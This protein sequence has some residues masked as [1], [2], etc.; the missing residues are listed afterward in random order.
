MRKFL[1]AM[2]AMAVALTFPAGSSPKPLCGLPDCCFAMPSRPGATATLPPEPAAKPASELEPLARHLKE[3]AETRLQQYLPREQ[4]RAGVL[5]FYR[6]RNF[7]PL[8]AAEGKPRAGQAAEFLAKVAA[9]GLDPA[10]YPMPKFDDADPAKLAANELTT[11]NSVLTFARHASIGRVAFSRASGAVYYDHKAPGAAEVLG[12]L[13]ESTNIGVTLDAFNP[14]HPAYK[15]LKAQLAAVRG[16]KS[17]GSTTTAV[18]RRTKTQER[19]G[20]KPSPGGRSRPKIRSS[21]TKPTAGRSPPPPTPSS[22]T[23]SAGVGC[24]TISATPM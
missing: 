2:T 1:L 8:W 3:L 15:A 14:Q 13:A 12:R 11:T 5:A 6:S 10:D 17:D 4:D 9:D 7:A 19:P 22:P 21:T 18:R 16:G 24:R 23:S 20:G